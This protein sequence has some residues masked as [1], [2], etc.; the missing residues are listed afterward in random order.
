M[1][2]RN[3]DPYSKKYR[4]MEYTARMNRAMDYIREHLDKRLTLVEVAEKA[5]FSPFHFHRIFS[6]CVG[7]TLNT[8]INPTST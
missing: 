2:S 1:A 7:E 8:F 6:S 4:R 5:N 3:Q